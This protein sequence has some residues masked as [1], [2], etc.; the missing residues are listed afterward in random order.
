MVSMWPEGPGTRTGSQAG[1]VCSGACS[2]AL[3]LTLTNKNSR[4]RRKFKQNGE[5]ATETVDKEGTRKLGF[6]SPFLGRD[7]IILKK[8]STYF[9]RYFS[10]SKI[11]V[12]VLIGSVCVSACL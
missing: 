9:L 8:Y 10:L 12:L 7:M 1:G 5:D 6:W 3:L 2:K 11:V 4:G